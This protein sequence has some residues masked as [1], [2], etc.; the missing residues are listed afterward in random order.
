[1]N[2]RRF[3]P[4]WSVE[5]RA[6]LSVHRYLSATANAIKPRIDQIIIISV[7]VIAAV[8]LVT[9]ALTDRDFQLPKTRQCPKSFCQPAR[10]AEH[11]AA[12]ADAGA[13]LHKLSTGTRKESYPQ[14]LPSNAHTESREQTV[15]SL[16]RR[17]VIGRPCAGS[18]VHLSTNPCRTCAHP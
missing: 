4:P 1:M 2:S 11:R 5:T 6:Q 12:R 9:L 13:A 14:W 10:P 7:A 15:G 17:S 16:D 8:P 18:F 3:P